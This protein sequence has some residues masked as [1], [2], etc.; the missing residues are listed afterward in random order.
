MNKLNKEKKIRLN[1]YLSHTGVVSS[2]RKADKLIQSG[3]IEVNGKLISNLGQVINNDDIVKFHGE[4]IKIKEKFYLLLNKPKGFIT[5]TKDKFKRKTVMD[6]IPYFFWKKN[7]FPVGRLDVNTTGIL[8]FTNDGEISNKL[9][10]PKYKIKKIYNVTL[11]KNLDYEDFNKI[12]NGKIFL[13][14]GRVK[15]F[16]IKRIKNNK[17]QVA[18]HIG[19]NRIIKRMFRKLNYKVIDLDRIVFGNFFK[20]NIKCGKFRIIKKNEIKMYL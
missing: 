6:L 2:R 10:H 3:V 15:V 20:K 12:K 4:R 17:V 18:I 8:L 19:W 11:N 5:T 7:V 9:T 14:E 1:K 13:K 16:N